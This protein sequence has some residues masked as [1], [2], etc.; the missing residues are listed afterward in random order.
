MDPKNEGPVPQGGTDDEARADRPVEQGRRDAV[1]KLAYASPVLASLL[2]TK[3]ASAMGSLPP[4]P[5][6]P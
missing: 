3:N 6:P 5:D 2:F 1:A 4:P